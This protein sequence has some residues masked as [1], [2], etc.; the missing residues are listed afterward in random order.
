MLRRLEGYRAMILFGLPGSGR[1]T[2]SEYLAGIERSRVSV[3]RHK[4]VLVPEFVDGEIYT[5]S[6]EK[7]PSARF[8][9]WVVESLLERL[10]CPASNP[11]I[12]VNGDCIPTTKSLHGLNGLLRKWGIHDEGV[13]S[14]NFI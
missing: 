11:L 6:P 5:L 4:S 10:A 2:S 13:V 9:K 3:G 1:T 7:L 12:V 14:I 8:T